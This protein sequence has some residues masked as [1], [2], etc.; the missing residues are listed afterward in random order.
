MSTKCCSSSR[1]Q[2]PTIAL[3]LADKLP[4]LGHEIATALEEDSLLCEKHMTKQFEKLLLHPMQR[5][6]SGNAL[7]GDCFL[8]IDAL[9]ECEDVN[10][11]E[12]L[13]KLLKRVE[14]VLTARIR[15]LV[16]SRPDPPLIAG[17]DDMSN[18][19]LD[20]VQL[21]QAQVTSIKTDLQ[22]YIDYELTGL[23]P[24]YTKQNP[25]STLSRAWF[26]Q[27]DISL[28]VDKS[29]PLF[30]VA[31]TLCQ[32]LLLSNTPQEDLRTLL[33]QTHLHGLAT[34]LE[35]VY[36]PV[37]R[38]TLAKAKGR[39][40]EEKI[41]TLKH[42]IGSLVLLYEPLSVI[43]L[44]KLLDVSIQ[45]IGALVPPLRSVL[46]ISARADGTPDP[47]GPMTIF[48]LSFRDFLV[49]PDLGIDNEGG[50]FWISEKHA[51]A[52]LADRCLRLLDSQLQTCIFPSCYTCTSPLSYYGTACGPATAQ[53]TCPRPPRL[54]PIGVVQGY[55]GA[56]VL[57][58][59][60]TRRCID[61]PGRPQTSAER[62]F[63]R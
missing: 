38:Q 26:S 37:L 23:H 44:S 36:L 56:L 2:P 19:L 5:G 16:T 22:T 48:H 20:D 55:Q 9:D 1:W 58:C 14:D 13:L 39:S 34:G 57:V 40:R 43:S 28:L 12:I 63:A 21:E 17:F 29:H 42:F 51:H 49:G 59:Q 24:K 30:I 41:S 3:Q 25:F 4:G 8:V 54:L 11:I 46:S 50:E 18:D 47:Y 31:Y 33:S 10:H 60:M 7:P 15:I 53:L 35:S 61:P 27:N 45:D 62:R 32:L 52:K 6:L